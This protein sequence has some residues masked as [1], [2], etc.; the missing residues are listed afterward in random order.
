MHFVPTAEEVAHRIVDI[1][2]RHD[3]VIVEGDLLRECKDQLKIDLSRL[4]QVFQI[5]V[6]DR[7]YR[8]EGKPLSLRQLAAL[9]EVK[10]SSAPTPR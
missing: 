6:V 5:E 4:A 2:A 9:G 7:S 8:K 1:A 3:R 10:G